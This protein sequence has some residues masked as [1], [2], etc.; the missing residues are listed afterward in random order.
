MADD[1]AVDPPHETPAGAPAAHTAGAYGFSRPEIIVLSVV[2]LLVIS[3]SIGQWLKRREAAK[4]P[5]WTME[6]ILIDTL[7]AESAF[8]AAAAE[9]DEKTDV[10]DYTTTDVNTATRFDLMRLPGIGS[11][12]A[13]RIIAA[14][15]KNGPFVNLLDLQRVF[16]IGPRKAAALAGWVR[17]SEP[18]DTSAPSET[19]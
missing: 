18:P 16:G 11:V 1:Q 6:D 19:Q 10:P 7:R 15:E 9:T 14:R 17:F 5:A 4:I 13:D 12:L 3:L 8:T 2:S